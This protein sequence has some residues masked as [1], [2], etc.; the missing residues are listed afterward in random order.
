MLR[1]SALGQ[2]GNNGNLYAMII[3]GTS[4]PPPYAAILLCDQI[5]LNRD[6]ILHCTIP[7]PYNWSFQT[8]FTRRQNCLLGGMLVA[9]TDSS[10]F[11]LDVSSRETGPV[12]PSIWV[13]PSMYGKPGGP[14]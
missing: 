11:Q 4:T 12:Y 3:K 14:I 10:C 13:C 7:K 8:V 1:S 5:M 9:L 2:S 6:I